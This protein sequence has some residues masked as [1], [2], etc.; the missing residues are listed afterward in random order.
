MSEF[1]FK[2][3]LSAIATH[4][5]KDGNLYTPTDA[6]LPL[7]VRSVA[8]EE[9]E[10]REKEVEQWPVLEGL[11]KYAIG[12]QREHVLLAGRPGSGK[13]TALRQLVVGLAAEGLVPVLVQLKGDRTVPELIKAEFRQMKQRVTLEQI[14]DWL[15]DDR[16]VLLLDGVNEI[17]SDDLRR[18]LA[19]FREDNRTVPMIFTTRDLSLGGDGIG[20]RFEMKPLSPEQLKEFVEK[21]LG[22]NGDRLLGQLRDRLR[23]IAETPLLLKMLCDVFNPE[24]SEIPQNK[25]E[26]FQWFDNDYERIKKEIEYVPVSENFW[27]FKSEVLQYLAFFM[28]QADIQKP[29]ELWLTIPKSRAEEILEQ[30]LRRRGVVDAPTKA[31]MW[32]KDLRK[33]HLLQD[34]A[35]LGEIEFHHQ[36]FQEYYAAEYLKIEL[37][38]C[39]EWLQKQPDDPYTYFQYFYLN[40]LKWTESVAIVLSL[41]K[42]E[43]DAV[44]LV[45][46]A[47]EVDLM[48]GA[49]LAGAVRSTFQ[50]GNI[51]TIAT[52]DVEPWLRYRL[53]GIVQSEAARLTVLEARHN[54]DWRVR[55][56][57][58]YALGTMGLSEEI[59]GLIFLTQ[60]EEASVRRQACIT[61]G[62]VGTDQVISSL[63]K[64]IE[65]PDQNVRPHAASSLRRIDSEKSIE[66]LFKIAIESSK[67][68]ARETVL[69][70]IKG[71]R[72]SKVTHTFIEFSEHSNLD[73]R[74]A[75]ISALASISRNSEFKQPGIEKILLKFARDKYYE[76]RCIAKPNRPKP[77]KGKRRVASDN[78]GKMLE[79]DESIVIDYLNDDA[80]LTRQRAINALSFMCES[81]R[82][83]KSY[84]LPRLREILVTDSVEAAIIVIRNIQSNCKFYNYEIH[85]KAQARASPSNQQI[86]PNGLSRIE[87]TL[88]K[89][90]KRT[91]K[92][93][94][95]PQYSAKYAITGN[96]TIVEGNMEVKGD[97]V[98]TK[99]VNNYADDPSLLQTIQDL[100]QK[101]TDL[102]KFITDL[103]TQN[104]NLQTEAE[105]EAARNQAI[106]HLQTT[107][108]ALWKNIRAQMRTLKQQLLNPERHLQATKATIVEVTKAYW[109]QSLI[110]KAIVTYIDKLS[111]TPDQGA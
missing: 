57:V 27:D 9:Q 92:M 13:S 85:Q 14:E 72:F 42:E 55:R 79:L 97:H 74:M 21:R 63:S 66:S 96:P 87:S 61:L 83:S 4:Y 33:Y 45:T 58:A 16:L 59:D 102:Q 18:D 103:E 91:T 39:P 93:A 3:Y 94:E 62:Y 81:A 11:R 52:L 65:D 54:S 106:T 29:T 20:K 38:R 88:D 90:D 51:T 25:G 60:D 31:K 101:N 8:R 78:F 80:A 64:A 104:P 40:Y 73:V 76:I 6:L 82:D 67:K 47:L 43:K 48:L 56:Q 75:A 12:D 34:A 1:D 46:Q 107:N 2:P 35:K 36:L 105:A 71:V 108:P 41:I 99:I 95:Q 17:P 5:S 84:L 22:E 89:I 26:L 24:T 109:E 30:W 32:L 19:Q 23:E 86:S 50:E 68:Y 15:I 98:G 37:E 10:G 69:K 7:E 44:D 28:I 100:L 110:A 70:T 53:L 111:E 49:R 77:K